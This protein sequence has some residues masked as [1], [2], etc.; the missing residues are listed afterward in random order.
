MHKC[1]FC[2]FRQ[3]T[4]LKAKEDNSFS[5]LWNSIIRGIQDFRWNN[6]VSPL[7]CLCEI[8]LY[9][10]FNIMQIS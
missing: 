9:N 1:Y 10:F 2:F 6:N 8:T 7:P 4:F 5:R 3:C